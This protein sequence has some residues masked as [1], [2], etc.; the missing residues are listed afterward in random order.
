MKSLTGRIGILFLDFLQTIVLAL[1]IFMITY[2]FLIQPHEVKGN[3]MHPNFLDG[4]RLLTDKITY[5]FNEPRR[6]DVIVFQA[7]PDRA[8]D[9]IKR[10]VAIPEEIIQVKDNRVYVNSQLL[11][12]VYISPDIF[13][14][15]GAF[16]AEGK[17]YTL[18][19]DEY[20]VM[21]DNREHSLDS[22]SWGPIKKKE[23]IGKAWLIYWPPQK[24]GVIPTVTFAGF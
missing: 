9:F 1:A 8:K 2:L 24:F 20:L 3:S 16:L 10:V 4:E 18:G 11:D 14:Q 6:G 12:E 13:T 23:I 15:P 5:R 19:T 17:T 22:R 7:P 21:G